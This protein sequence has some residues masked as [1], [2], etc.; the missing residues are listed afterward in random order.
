MLEAKYLK[1]PRQHLL[2][3]DIPNKACSKIWRLCKK[4]IPFLAQ[5]ISKVPKGGNNIRIGVDRIMD[6]QPINNKPGIGQILSF[7]DNIGLHY[8]DQISQW[9]IHSQLWTRW[10][11]S[12]IP[13]DLEA[14]LANLQTHLHAYPQCYRHFWALQ[15]QS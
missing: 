6:Q 14:S 15:P 9:D 7:F 5:N 11:F 13:V 2:D 3:Y 10:I 8:L 12:E 1:S 4:A